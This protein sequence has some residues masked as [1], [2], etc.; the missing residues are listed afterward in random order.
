MI[1]CALCSVALS[2]SAQLIPDAS[3][4]TKCLPAMHLTRD[5]QAQ[6]Y[7]YLEA[8]LFSPKSVTHPERFLL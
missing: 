5:T 8:G 2:L 4:R 3:C 1:H 6:V 7:A